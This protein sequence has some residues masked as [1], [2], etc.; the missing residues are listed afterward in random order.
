MSSEHITLLIFDLREVLLDEL[1]PEHASSSQFGD[2]HIEVHSNGPE[3]RDS[4][5][6]IVDI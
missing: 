3:E 6:N 5:C 1:S 2:F 4:G